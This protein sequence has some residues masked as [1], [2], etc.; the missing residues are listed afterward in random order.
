MTRTTLKNGLW[1]LVI[2]NN[3]SM[4]VND[5]LQWWTSHSEA[6]MKSDGRHNYRI[7]SRR[8][9]V[10][11]SWVERKGDGY[12]CLFDGKPL[13]PSRGRRFPISK[14]DACHYPSIPFIF[15]YFCGCSQCCWSALIDYRHYFG[16][17]ACTTS[18]EQGCPRQLI[19]RGFATSVSTLNFFGKP[20]LSK[21]T[22]K[23]N[24]VECDS[25]EVL[26]TIKSHQV[27]AEQRWK[28]LALVGC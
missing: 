17:T 4:N 8:S 22:V 7:C 16:T 10:T 6:W 3:W 15:P 13:T 14:R 24:F 5:G 12:I 25:E 26:E 19:H 28:P 18:D 9:G 1:L 11:G 21:Q 2:V 23:N 27:R 20:L